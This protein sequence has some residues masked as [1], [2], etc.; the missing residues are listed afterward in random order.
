MTVRFF[1]FLLFCLWSDIG[2]AQVNCGEQPKDLPAEI[3]QDVKGEID[4]KAQL[5]TKLLGNAE[6]KGAVQTSRKEVYEKHQNIDKSKIDR[7][8]IWVHCQ[9]IMNN[10]ALSAADKTQLWISVYREL[11]ASPRSDVPNFGKGSRTASDTLKKFTMSMP[12]KSI[13]DSFGSPTWEIEIEKSELPT[14]YK[15]GATY[16]K[17]YDANDFDLFLAT[18]DKLPHVAY[19]ILLK[20]PAHVLIPTLALVGN[21]GTVAKYIDDLKFKVIAE[22]CRD[23]LPIETIGP[24]LI[25][26]IC[27]FSLEEGR[28]LSYSFGF[29]VRKIDF[30]ACKKGKKYT[31]DL[32]C[33]RLQGLQPVFVFAHQSWDPSEEEA[34]KRW[35]IMLTILAKA[36]SLRGNF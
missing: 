35:K 6:L 17:Q 4:G 18:G 24:L 19:A 21:D 13:E 8:A 1:L 14:G 7:Y 27:S 20:E 3:Q 23:T 2:V 31:Q 9:S 36:Y 12:L 30:E 29:D 34:N 16:L 25:P 32:K 22:T 26:P 10:S 11:V 15:R 5:F 33:S 28:G